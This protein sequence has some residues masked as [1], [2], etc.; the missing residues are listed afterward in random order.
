[1]LWR[2]GDLQ[3]TEPL[4]LPHPQSS[5]TSSSSEADWL[6]RGGHESGEEGT[7]GAH[8]IYLSQGL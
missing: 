3:A 7:L 1:M 8:A 5:L 6:H 4:N 2:R